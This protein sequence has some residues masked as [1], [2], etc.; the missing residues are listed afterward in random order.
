MEHEKVGV[1]LLNWNSLID[2]C[3]CIASI[4]GAND[5]GIF[6]YV[7]DNASR[8]N[9]ADIIAQKFSAITVLK[10][11]E[12]LGFCKGNNVGI[13]RALDDGMQYILVLNNDTLVP[14]GAIETM[15]KEFK[16]IKGTGA[17]SPVILEYP[18][19][20]RV[21][22]AKAKWD[23]SRA[24]FNMNPDK[25]NYEELKGKQPWKS[26]FA[27]GCCMLSSAEVIQKVGL[28]DERYFAYYDEADWCKRLERNG[29]S[30]DV[31]A[32]TFIYHKVS[33]TTPSLV[34]TYLMARNRK[35]WMKENLS[36]PERMKSFTYLVKELLW[37]F[38]NVN[39]WVKGDY[40]KAHSKALLRGWVDYRSGRFG[41]WNKKTEEVI[42]PKA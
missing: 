1:I 39:G 25:N 27:C 23:T 18:A 13:Q 10:Q 2:T 42:F 41:K 30:S 16:N 6:I 5:P 29:Y 11:T 7:V 28:L 40:T 34:S 33:R 37:H 4:L 9:E 36:F 38:C 15:V 21:W 14:A 12:N 26:E 20:D 32:A 35:L 17:L 31:T 8:N 19:T 3:E 22:F 24:Q